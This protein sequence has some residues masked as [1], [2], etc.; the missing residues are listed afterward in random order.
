MPGTEIPKLKPKPWAAEALPAGLPARPQGRA[1]IKPTCEQQGTAARGTH[2][3]VAWPSLG[4]PGSLPSALGPKPTAG[5]LRGV[6]GCSPPPPGRTGHWLPCPRACLKDSPLCNF[7]P[8]DRG[9]QGTGWQGTVGSGGCRGRHSKVTR[10]RGAGSR[11]AGLVGSHAQPRQPWERCGSL[12]PL[13]SWAPSPASHGTPSLPGPGEPGTAQRLLQGS[14][15][16]S[17]TGKLFS[18]RLTRTPA[19]PQIALS[20]RRRGGCAGRQDS[21]ARIAGWAPGHPGPR[22]S[23]SPRTVTLSQPLVHSVPQFPHRHQEVGRG[24]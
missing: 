11:E 18:L 10:G 24:C 16:P 1:L 21:S 17:V 7:L 13:E 4:S 3:A 2:S 22:L 8:E 20:A 19:A 14:R 9:R 5:R 23:S 6:S 12:G 15:A